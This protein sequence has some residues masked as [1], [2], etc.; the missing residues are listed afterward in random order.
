V[1]KASGFKVIYGPIRAE[2]LPAFLNRGMKALP[3]MRRKTFPLRER[4]VLIPV[5]LVSALK[6]VLVAVLAMALFSGLLGS[7]PFL[8]E[9]LQHGMLALV[10]MLGA[11]T[12][13]AVLTPLCLPWLPGRPF[14]VKGLWIGLVAAAV[15]LFSRWEPSSSPAYRLETWAWVLMVLALT[16]FL[17]MSFTGAST[18]TS[19]SGV[20][21]E[22]RWAVPFQIAV[23]FAGLCLWISS[24]VT[25]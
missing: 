18:Y 22:M 16:S 10:A 14:S 7:G 2:D 24:N 11:V 3:E 5:E 23:G 20:K 21:K 15:L 19:L 12:A 4:I 13:G 8:Q 1:K 17:A 9:A 25:M 6:A